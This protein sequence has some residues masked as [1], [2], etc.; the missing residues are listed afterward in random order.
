MAILLISKF[1]Q[2]FIHKR[3]ANKSITNGIMQRLFVGKSSV[4]N[5]P[6]I[7]EQ[8]FKLKEQ[9]EQQQ[10]FNIEKNNQYLVENNLTCYQKI[11]AKTEAFLTFIFEKYLKI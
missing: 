6:E 1:Y 8:T 4:I 2:D 10:V 5:D 9:H 11:G 7:K 3:D